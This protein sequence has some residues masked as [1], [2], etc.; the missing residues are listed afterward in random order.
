MKKIVYTLLILSC[1][2]SFN[3][4]KKKVTGC[5]DATATNYNS[6]ATEDDGSCTFNLAVGQNYQGGIIAY[7][8]Q[9]GEPG[10][11]AGETHGIIASPSDLSSGVQWYNGSSMVTGATSNSGGSNNTNTIVSTQG[12]GNYAAKLCQ[13]LVL[14]GYSDWYLPSKAELTVLYSKKTSIGGFTAANYWSSTEYAPSGAGN[15]WYYSTAG[16]GYA[17]YGNKANLYAVRAIRAF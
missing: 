15:A 11:V 1:M 12:S 3:S 13:D 8:Y 14:G 4:C 2:V 6:N 17:A 7:V 16:N 5:T 10:Y 9:S